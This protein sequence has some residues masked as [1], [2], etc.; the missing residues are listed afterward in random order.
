MIVW[1]KEFRFYR[2]YNRSTVYQHFFRNTYLSFNLTIR[3][4]LS[5]RHTRAGVS[6]VG[7]GWTYATMNYFMRRGSWVRSY[8]FLAFSGVSWSYASFQVPYSASSAELYKSGVHVPLLAS[9][10]GAN[11]ALTLTTEL[12][13]S[14]LT[15]LTLLTQLNTSWYVALYSL[16]V[17][18]FWF[19]CI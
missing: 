18:L 17:K 2:N 14:P 12:G 15:L 1:A 7:S 16:L 6:A 19:R 13:Y 8:P 11:A 5:S 3:P 10:Y 4:N 9:T